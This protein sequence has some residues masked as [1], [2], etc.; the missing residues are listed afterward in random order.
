MGKLNVR[1]LLYVDDAVL[2]LDNKDLLHATLNSF[3]NAIL[4]MSL[5][6][7]VRKT[8]ALFLIIEIV[9]SI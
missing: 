8:K 6:V 9:V 5:R 2:L 3:S 4:S 7:N 1:I